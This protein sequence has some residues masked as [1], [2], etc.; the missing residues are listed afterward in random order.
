MGE[1]TNLPPAIEQSIIR[2]G[3]ITV[4]YLSVSEQGG[5]APE[6]EKLQALDWMRDLPPD[7]MDAWEQLTEALGVL[8]RLHLEHSEA[9]T[10]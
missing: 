8:N 4:V 7:L 10:R 2:G 5:D 9:M 1:F 6:P 3:A